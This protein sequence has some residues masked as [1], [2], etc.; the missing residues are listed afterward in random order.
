MRTAIVCGGPPMGGKEMM[1]LELGEGLRSEV[2]DVEFVTSHWTNGD[3]LSHLRAMGFRAHMVWFG[4]ISATLSLKCVYMTVHQLSRW[5]HLLAGYRRFLQ[6]AAPEKVIHTNWQSLLMILPYVQPRR[7]LFWL[8]EVVPNKPQYRWVFGWFA[9]RLGCF[10]P[11]SHAV[12]DSLRRIGIPEEKIRVIHNGL[13]DPVPD[14]RTTR[15]AVNG[16]RIGIAG[17]IGEYKGHDDLLEAFGLLRAKHA[18]V[19]LHIF[20]TGTPEYESKLKRR[21]EELG[22]SSRVVWHG[23]VTDRAKIYPAVDIV[24]VPSRCYDS[25]PTVAIEAAFFGLPVVGTV[26]GGLPEII[27]DGVTGCLTEAENPQQLAVRLDELLGNVELRKRMGTAAR[28]RAETHFSRKR[29]V[30]EFVQL[31]SGGARQENGHAEA[32]T[33]SGRRPDFNDALS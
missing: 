14:P 20:G 13:V 16:L 21:A 18:T 28:Q 31:L 10:V 27:V 8:H 29:F 5:P 30:S 26:R 17:R 7:D 22:V 25:L 4:F 11:V 9:R 6:R 33:Y 24:A 19:E 15:H 1:A 12:A 2:D 32:E 23:F 3:F